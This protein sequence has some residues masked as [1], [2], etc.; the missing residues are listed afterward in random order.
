MLPFTATGPSNRF[1]TTASLLDRWTRKTRQ[2][3]G[4]RCARLPGVMNRQ[5]GYWKKQHKRPA[6]ENPKSFLRQMQSDY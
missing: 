6:T 2:L 3:S 1:A 4:R 5:Q